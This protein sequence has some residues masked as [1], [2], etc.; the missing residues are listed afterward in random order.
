MCDNGR[1]FMLRSRKRF[2]YSRVD[3]KSAA[4]LYVERLEGTF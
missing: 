3:T 1:A 4:A 2:V